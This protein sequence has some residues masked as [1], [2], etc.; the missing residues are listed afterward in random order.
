MNVAGAQ[1]NRTRAATAKTKPSETPFASAPSTGTGN[2][3]VSIEA[4]RNAPTP[5]TTVVEP[6][7]RRKT[8]VAARYAPTPTSDTG[9]TTARS[10]AGGSALELIRVGRRLPGEVEAAVA[11]GRDAEGREGEHGRHD[12]RD[13]NDE[14]DLRVPLKHGNPLHEL[15]HHG[16]FSDRHTWVTSPE[17]GNG[18]QFCEIPRTGERKGGSLSFRPCSAP[19]SS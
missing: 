8:K 7:S 14:R 3:S 12:H 6:G 17:G 9:A 4:S 15:P 16:G 19:T 1:P 10:F 13:Q 5:S 18:V 2:R 11:E